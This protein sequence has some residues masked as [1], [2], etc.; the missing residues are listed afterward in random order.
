MNSLISH[1]QAATPRVASHSL[2]IKQMSH[3]LAFGLI[4]AVSL[5][6]LATIS[7]ALDDQWNSYLHGPKHSSFNP[8]ATSFTPSASASL[9]TNWVFAVPPPTEDGQ[10][11]NALIAS[12]TVSDGV[13]Y[14]GAYTG[15][16]YAIRENADSSGDAGTEIW[17]RSL[18]YD[19][20]DSNCPDRGVSSTAAIAPDA[21]RGGQST[22]YV[23][24]GDGNLYALLASTGEVIWSSPLADIAADGYA[25]TSPTVANGGVYMGIASDCGRPLIRGGLVEFDQ[26]SG[27]L[28]HTY[29]SVPKGTRGG[30]IW[31]SPVFEQGSVWVGIGNAPLNRAH[32]GD[33]FAIVRL[34]E[35]LK[36]QDR[37]VVPN[38]SGTDLDWGSSPTLFDA[39]LNGVLTKMVGAA[40]K[41]GKFY[42]F[43]SD[44][45]GSGPV[46]KRMLGAIG[47]NLKTQ[48]TLLAAAIWDFTNHR[49]FVG[50][51][52][53]KIRNKTVLGS[54]RQ[55]DPA[56]GNVI[57]ATPI[58][59][60]P[61]IGTPTLS[62]GGVIAVATYNQTT[63]DRNAVCLVN[64]ADGS[65]VKTIPEDTP[66]FAQPVFADT[67]L[68]IATTGGTLTAYSVAP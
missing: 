25:W 45:L 47:G 58:P 50:S 67:H 35:S 68:F 29:H 3:F 43:K 16:F 63:P 17:H 2:T 20:S 30:S 37:W 24:G 53:T 46:W 49:L 18:G 57:W 38:T 14:I 10:P 39:T 51:N 61:V 41:N 52:E 66:I 4:N 7:P 31:T 56:T 1:N 64:A 55:L 22:V 9:V 28:L 8:G 62:A 44:D 11:G 48:G 27:A 13:I 60:G 42:A 21:S 65:V 23:G 32:L 33:C 12:P 59:E 6:L 36:R 5:C 34:D 15:V 26:A 40:S 19:T 54:V